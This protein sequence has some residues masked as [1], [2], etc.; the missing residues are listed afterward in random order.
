MIRLASIGA[1]VT[2]E[3]SADQVQRVFACDTAS[4]IV[5]LQGIQTSP[6]AFGVDQLE[7]L[8]ADQG[9]LLFIESSALDGNLTTSDCAEPERKRRG[10]LKKCTAINCVS[11]RGHD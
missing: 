2:Q 3:S 6:R 11:F 10:R 8:F 5:K 1:P 7:Q 4:Q 9:D